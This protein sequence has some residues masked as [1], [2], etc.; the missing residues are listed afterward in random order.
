MILSNSQAYFSVDFKSS[1][2]V[3][4]DDI[5]RFERIL[6]GEE[7]LTV[8]Q[9]LVKLC[10]F[11]SLEGEMPG[12]KIIR[13][14]PSLEILQFLIVQFFNLSQYSLIADICRFHSKIL[15]RIIKFY[16]L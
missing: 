12:V 1:V 5:R 3:H 11:R 15:L 8:V 6:V 9:S 2:F 7:N 13:Q 14:R 10:I 16:M 4:E